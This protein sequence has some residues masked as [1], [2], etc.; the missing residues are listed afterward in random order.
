MEL[1]ILRDQIS[2]FHPFYIRVHVKTITR[3]PSTA[4][5]QYL[6]FFLTW[7][8]K[9]TL[10]AFRENLAIALQPVSYS[11]LVKS[12]TTNHYC[13][14]SRRPLPT[15]RCCSFIIMP[16]YTQHIS[17]HTCR[18]GWLVWCLLR[19]T[20][21]R[22]TYIII[23]ICSTVITYSTT[24]A[25]ATPRAKATS[26][27]KVNATLSPTTAEPDADMARLMMETLQQVNWY[28]SKSTSPRV[29]TSPGIFL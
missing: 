6:L 13:A 18:H 17:T 3:D 2:S 16:V 21:Q 1:K 11:L 25:R 22:W 8:A 28:G 10:F 14:Q 23:V 27:A 4:S 5:E 19:L 12:Q 7:V 26:T 15:T 29:Q 24:T 9:F 20:P